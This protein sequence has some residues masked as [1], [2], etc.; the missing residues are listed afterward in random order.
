MGYTS[1]WRLS[2]QISERNYK[3]LVSD[4]KQ[5][6]TFVENITEPS[7]KFTLHDGL[8]ETKG[9]AYYANSFNFNGDA[10][11][12]ADHEDFALRL[13]ESEGGFCKTARKPYDLAVSLI[14]ISLKYHIRSTRITSDGDNDDWR[15]AFEKWNEIFPNR[16]FIMRFKA[17]ERDSKDKDGSLVIVPKGLE[18]T[19]EKF[20]E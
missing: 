14:L 2:R 15:G 18:Y 1:Y 4:M 17:W 8:G 12:N 11:I 5:I 20:S 9:V 13:G 10:S 16:N 19:L 7:E 3:K 6:E